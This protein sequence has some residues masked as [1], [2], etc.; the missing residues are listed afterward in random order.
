MPEPR[1]ETR[2]PLFTKRH[3]EAL[4]GALKAARQE[5]IN[6]EHG[7]ATLTATL[8]GIE[9]A[10]RALGDTLMDD[11]PRFDRERFTQAAKQEY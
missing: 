6:G 8:W 10:E 5:A 7:L 3:Y 1:H 4:A 2:K 9:R 11:N